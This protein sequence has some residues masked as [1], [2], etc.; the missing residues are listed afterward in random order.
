MQ[1]LWTHLP[2]VSWW[3]WWRDPFFTLILA[4]NMFLTLFHSI[5][6][7]NGRLWRYFGA[8]AGGVFPNFLGI[9]VFFVGLT[10]GLW[11]LALVGIAGGFPFREVS[12]AV[13]MWAVGFLIGAR[14]SDSWFSHIRLDRKG[15]RPNPGL[16]STRFYIV[17]AFVLLILFA[18][19]LWREKTWAL[20]GIGVGA[21]L[22]FAVLPLLRILRTLPSPKVRRLRREPWRPGAPPPAPPPLWVL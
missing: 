20:V 22:F 3:S 10:G 13:A 1:E 19:G 14:L 18:P 15:Y 7:L 8:I 11:V 12:Q 2:D 5:Q 21:L 9:M 6:E 4:V 16:A 17:E